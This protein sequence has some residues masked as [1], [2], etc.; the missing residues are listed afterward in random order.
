MNLL[1]F[2]QKITFFLLL[3]SLFF[4]SLSIAEKPAVKTEATPKVAMETSLGKIV[5]ELYPKKAPITVENFL[6]YVND[7]FYDGTIFHRIVPGFVVQG[8]GFTFDFKQKTTRKPIQNEAN[9]G[10][11][12]DVATLSM[13]RTRATH[14]ATSQFF[15]NT[16]NNPALDPNISSAG[17]AVF[18]KVIEGFNIVKKIEKQPRGVHRQHP[19]APNYAVIIEKAYVLDTTKPTIKKEE[20]KA[21]LKKEVMKKKEKIPTKAIVKK[22][23]IK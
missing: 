17:Y 22:E 12:N 15:I 20:P 6:Q 8:G 9:N 16:V 13:A 3:P 18:G 2:K 11:K 21:E 10:L 5:I 7:K 23:A 19:E 4:S 14:S 1:N